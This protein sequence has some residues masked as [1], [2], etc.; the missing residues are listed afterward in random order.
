MRSGDAGDVYGFRV[1]LIVVSPYAKAKYI[2][3]TPYVHDFGS[4]LHF[5]EKTFNLPSLGY[6]DAVADDFSDCFDFNQPPLPFQTIRAAFE[7]GTIFGII[8]DAAVGP[9]R[10]LKRPTKKGAR[11]KACPNRPS[12]LS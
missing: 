4:I 7:G 5:V 8:Q 9:G 3:T 10:R 11:P 6:A 2:S 12:L 1:P